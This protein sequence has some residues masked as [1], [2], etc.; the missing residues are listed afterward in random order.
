MGPAAQTAALVAAVVAAAALLLVTVA[1]LR[2]TRA[3]RERLDRE[4]L[5]SRDEVAQLS[6]RV[7]E[8][9]QE[10]TETRRASEEERDYVITSLAGAGGE[11]GPLLRHDERRDRPTVGG[12]VEDQ[13]VGLLARG[14]DASRLRARA[15]GV[16]VRTVALG[17]GVRRALSADVLD[18][19]A[20]EA[21]VARRRSRRERRRELREAR[22]LVRGTRLAGDRDEQPAGRHREDAA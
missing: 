4:L 9:S 10:V 6:R 22:R 1:L 14:Q 2:A 20:A 21:H 15:V 3:Q 13:L 5:T 16:V 11:Q 8:L 7:A 17:H 18:R 12:V 19:A